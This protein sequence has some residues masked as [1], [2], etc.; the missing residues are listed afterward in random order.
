MRDLA[1]HP[2]GP[3]ERAKGTRCLARM[4]TRHKGDYTFE[5]VDHSTRRVQPCKAPL[6]EE[7]AC[8]DADCDCCS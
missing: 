8:D 4:E 1:L 7:H 3:W 6:P 5:A 2:E